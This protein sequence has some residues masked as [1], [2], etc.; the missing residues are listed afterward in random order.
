MAETKRSVTTVAGRQKLAKA[1]AGLAALPKIKQ[2]VWGD[3]GIG[4][5]GNPKVPTGKE[6]NLY[7]RLLAKDISGV[8][9]IGTDQ[10]TARYTGKLEKEELAGKEISEIGLLDAEG[11]LIVIRTFSKK[12]KDD[13]IPMTFDIDEIF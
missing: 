6:T 4:E 1:H 5:D 12:G 13:D 7:N 11:T 10:T 2:M 3:G 8:E 9:M